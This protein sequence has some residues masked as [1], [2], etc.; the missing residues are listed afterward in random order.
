MELKSWETWKRQAWG[1]CDKCKNAHI[2]QAISKGAQLLWEPWPCAKYSGACWRLRAWI[3]LTLATPTK[4]PSVD[5]WQVPRQTSVHFQ[6]VQRKVIAHYLSHK[7]FLKWSCWLQHF[8]GWL[9]S[10]AA[11]AFAH[12]GAQVLPGTSQLLGALCCVREPMVLESPTQE[13]WSSSGQQQPRPCPFSV[14]V[15]ELEAGAAISNMEE[16][17]TKPQPSLRW[18]GDEGRREEGAMLKVWSKKR[19]GMSW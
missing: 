13:Q 19:G 11:A 7:H 4:I 9:G 16:K 3:Q 6:D 1:F 12:H 8:Q 18:A 10:S 15:L 17:K 5:L 2:C 14:V